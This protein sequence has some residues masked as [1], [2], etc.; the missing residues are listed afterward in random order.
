MHNSFLPLLLHFYSYIDTRSC[1]CCSWKETKWEIK[2]VE[3][4]EVFCEERMKVYACEW[5]SG[6]N[7]RGVYDVVLKTMWVKNQKTSNELHEITI[8]RQKSEYVKTQDGNRTN[9][10]DTTFFVFLLPMFAFLSVVLFREFRVS[11]S[12]YSSIYSICF[13]HFHTLK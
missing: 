9:G 13:V 1:R 2:S 5:I 7:W 3:L 11:R 8:C 10:G 6:K 4:V 12:L